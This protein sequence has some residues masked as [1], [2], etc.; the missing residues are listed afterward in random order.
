VK[1]IASPREEV[2]DKRRWEQELKLFFN[3]YSDLTNDLELLYYSSLS[4]INQA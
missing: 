1:E 3:N 4:L 2:E